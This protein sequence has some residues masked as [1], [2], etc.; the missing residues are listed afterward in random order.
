M[1]NADGPASIKS[2]TWCG[3]REEARSLESSRGVMAPSLP[4][5]RSRISP[6]RIAQRIA[7]RGLAVGCLRRASVRKPQSHKTLSEMISYREPVK[8][9]VGRPG[10]YAPIGRSSC[11]EV[12]WSTSCPG[13]AYFSTGMPCET[14]CGIRRSRVSCC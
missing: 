1:Q 9:Q 12:G 4:L 8:R 5:T 2:K 10:D 3:I 6:Y 14:G 13:D 11:G 7:P